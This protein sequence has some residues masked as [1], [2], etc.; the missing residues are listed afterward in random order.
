MDARRGYL[1]LACAGVVSGVVA[2]TDGPVL[3]RA[4]PGLLLV[5][6]FPG[7]GLT[8]A[9]LSHRTLSLPERLLVALGSS[10]MVV[11][12]AGLAMNLTPGG[13]RL[14]T[15]VA[16]LTAVTVTTSIVAHLRA[17]D[18]PAA[19]APAP[20]APAVRP[21]RSALFGLG[22]TLTV[23]A[24]VVAVWGATNQPVANFTELWAIPRSDPPG[25]EV[26]VR[27]L[28]AGPRSYRL[29]LESDGRVVQDWSLIELSAG[30]TWSE[31]LPVAPLGI[32][33][34]DLRARLF[35]SGE[36]A[37]PY[38]EVLVRGGDAAGGS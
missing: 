30:E 36:D 7:L 15:S 27:N 33:R 31:T 1:V 29:E 17:R 20:T 21:G 34:T 9:L 26:G 23:A 5:L 6:L 16:V 28:E 38:R 4:V 18:E 35:L 13:L 32:D 25:L 19:T 37:E 12:L 10:L 22:A 2:A 14:E 11:V 3:V 8:G 24:F